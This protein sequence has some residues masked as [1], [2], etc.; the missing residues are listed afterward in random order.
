MP[1]Q[2]NVHFGLAREAQ[3]A[4]TIIQALTQMNQSDG[5]NTTKSVLPRISIARAKVGGVG[6]V[7][8]VH[9]A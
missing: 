3:W 5:K 6:L 1:I 7:V 2:E 4:S 8:W 9:I